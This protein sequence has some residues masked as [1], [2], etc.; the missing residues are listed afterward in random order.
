MTTATLLRPRSLAIHGHRF[1]R[2]VEI[3]VPLSVAR[4]LE[5]DPRF[6][7]TFSAEVTEEAETEEPGR[8]A[9]KKDRLVAIA[10][11]IGEL[12]IDDDDAYTNDGKPDARKLTQMLG[13]QVTAKERDE[14]L[15]AEAAPGMEPHKGEGIKPV[16]NGPLDPNS[17]GDM[18]AE[19]FANITAKPVDAVHAGTQASGVVETG[20]TPEQGQSEP[21]NST[22][23][24]LQAAEQEGTTDPEQALIRKAPANLKVTHKTEP[25]SQSDPTTEGAKEI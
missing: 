15:A 9:N 24:P 2:N 21:N 13:W 16:N 22:G 1:E 11:A 6:K 23:A 4:E 3:P 20:A 17:K 25:P 19:D 5:G 7:V 12:D 10:K 14:A 18:S 8:P